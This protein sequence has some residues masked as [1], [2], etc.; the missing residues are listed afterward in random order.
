VNGSPIPGR[1]AGATHRS[2]GARQRGVT[3]IEVVLAIVIVAIAA[4]AIMGAMAQ[5]T[6]RGAETMV[7][8]QAVAVAEGY[9]EE[10][11]LQPVASPGGAAPSG[12]A[13]YNDEDEYNGLSD[14][15]AYDQYGT[16]IPYLTGYNVSVAVTQTTALT[17]IAAAQARQ[18]NVTVTD[19]NGV[20]VVL[21]G[22]RANF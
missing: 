2:A 11:L 17:G 3:L 13:N 4:T 7:R 14:T 8:Q 21:T 5:I 19:P 15:G 10:I 22:Y 16:A 20:T 9:L 18:I 12:R 6:M 1:R